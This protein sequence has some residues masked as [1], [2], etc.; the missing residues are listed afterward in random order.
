MSICGPRLTSQDFSLE[1]H[2]RDEV[3]EGV[4]ERFPTHVSKACLLNSVSIWEY[5]GKQGDER[6]P[7]PSVA[8]EMTGVDLI[9]QKSDILKWLLYD[10]PAEDCVAIRSLGGGGHTSGMMADMGVYPICMADKHGSIF[11]PECFGLAMGIGSKDASFEYELGLATGCKIVGFDIADTGSEFPWSD[12]TGRYQFLHAALAAY[13]DDTAI[14]PKKTL[15]TLIKS[16]SDKG[17]HALKMS[18]GDTPDPIGLFKAAIVDV[19]Q[20]D[21][22]MQNLRH[23]IFD[24]TMV[25]ASGPRIQ[26]LIYLCEKLK[27]KGW[28]LIGRILNPQWWPR[29]MLMEP[30]VHATPIPGSAAAF[31]FPLDPV[32]E[33]IRQRSAVNL[34]LI[35]VV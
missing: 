35:R 1:P 11:P 20:E 12:G 2:S 18:L 15:R 17:I 34:C 32:K 23:L 22:L 30:V 19:I 25:A 14:P 6:S 10:H 7:T 3:W 16:I 5:I 27:E 33:N 13:D 24:V 29:H 26:E 9:M 28:R 8:T 4:A 21:E 31:P